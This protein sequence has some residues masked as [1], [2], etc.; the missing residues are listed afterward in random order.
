[1]DKREIVAPVVNIN[2]STKEALLE[3]HYNAHTALKEARRLFGLT[4]PHPRDFQTT[5]KGRYERARLVWALRATDLDL[6]VADMERMILEIDGSNRAITC[7][8]CG[9]RVVGPCTSPPGGYARCPV[10]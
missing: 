7:A 3:L 1:M 6:L 5:D 4:S 2:G 10:G 8:A 9:Q